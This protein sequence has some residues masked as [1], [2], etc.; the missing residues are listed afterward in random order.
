MILLYASIFILG[1]SAGLAIGYFLIDYL[2]G[3]TK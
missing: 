3:V 1:M 2:L